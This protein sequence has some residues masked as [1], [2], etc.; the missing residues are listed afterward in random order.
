MKKILVVEDEADLREVITESLQEEGYATEDVSSGNRAVALLNEKIAEFSLIV[1][2]VRMAD[3]DGTVVLKA[4]KE[5]KSDLP[6]II[7]TG[8]TDYPIK[9]LMEMGAAHVL[10]KP[11]DSERLHEH[12][13]NLIGRAD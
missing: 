7:F 9:E 2:D 6:V 5:L 1:S 12:I 10:G 4:A 3:G 13:R 11:I 8:Y